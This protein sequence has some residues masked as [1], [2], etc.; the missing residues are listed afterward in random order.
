[1]NSKTMY[2]MQSGPWTQNGTMHAGIWEQFMSCNGYEISTWIHCFNNVHTRCIAT[3]EAQKS[4]LFW[5]FSGVLWFYQERLFSRN[6]TRKPLN[7]INHRFLQTPLVNPL[8]FTM[9][10][11]CTLLIVL[12]FICKQY[13]RNEL[14]CLRR[15]C[16]LINAP[17]GHLCNLLRVLLTIT[18][19]K[20]RNVILLG[21][22][23][24]TEK[25]MFQ[26]LI[27]IR[28]RSAKTA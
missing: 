6:S 22:A 2:V 28:G 14:L 1:M 9:H 25:Y 20:A 23:E 24:E 3:G 10:L 11:V 18:S 19:P 15:D 4:P 27:R 12:S 5:R 13:F 8:V 17:G 21:H 16:C 7:V 26:K